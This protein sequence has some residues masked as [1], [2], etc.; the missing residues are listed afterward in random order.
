M[1]CVRLRGLRIQ[2]CGAALDCC[3]AELPMKRVGAETIDGSATY[4]C[5]AV[6]LTDE[7]AQACAMAILPVKV[8][9]SDDVMDAC[10]RMSTVLPLI[11]LVD[12]SMSAA[13]ERTLAEY[14]SACG[15]EIVGV[16]ASIERSALV[17][18]GPLARRFL[19]ALRTAEMRRFRARL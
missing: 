14:A 8:I 7:Q 9:R 16:P 5:L 1:P 13:E 10:S 18:G 11:V 12:E 19:D 3:Y 4:H 2:V 17:P 6:G 15:A